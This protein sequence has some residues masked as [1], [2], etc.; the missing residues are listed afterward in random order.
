MYLRQNW[1]AIAGSDTPCPIE[2][3]EEEMAEH[4]RQ[5]ER[6]QCR[7][8]AVALISE[9]LQIEEDGLVTHEN[10]DVVREAIDM[11]EEKWNEEI[12]G[13]PFPFKD[14]EYSYFLS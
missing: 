9:A 2:F 6:F 1:V 11:L 7:E 8:G 14:G 5:W 13:T 10:Y 3:S 4:E 12:T